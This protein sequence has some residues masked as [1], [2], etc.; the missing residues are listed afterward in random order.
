MTLRDTELIGKELMKY[1]F[2]R[3]SKDHQHY[4]SP[5]SDYGITVHFKQYG[6]IWTALITHY[7]DT[8]TQVISNDHQAVFSIEWLTEEHDKLVAAFKFLRS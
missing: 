1:G 8:H 3:N 4:I 5:R 2:Y 6:S 7:I